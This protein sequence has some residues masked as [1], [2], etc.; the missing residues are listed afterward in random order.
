M[1]IDS[2]SRVMPALLIRMST[3]PSCAS[4]SLNRVSAPSASDRLAGVTT[5]FG[6][7]WAASA[8][9]FSRRVPCRATLAPAAISVL[10]ISSPIPPEAPVTMARLPSRLNRLVMGQL[11]NLAV[12]DDNFHVLDFAFAH[13]RGN[14]NGAKAQPLLHPVRLHVN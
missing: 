13:G 4:A 9:S 11:L 14:G 6:P 7:S 2:W 5:A 10:A 3:P 12:L 8:S 1:R